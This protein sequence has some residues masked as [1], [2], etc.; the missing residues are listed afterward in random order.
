MSL[1]QM[2]LEKLKTVKCLEG[3]QKLRNQ[4]GAVFALTALLLPVLFGFMGLGYDVGNLY[5]HKARLQDTADATA[6]A[7]ARGYVNEL[8]KGSSTGVISLASSDTQTK[9]DT[10]IAALKTNAD[11]YIAKNNPVFQDKLRDD[12]RTEKFYSIGKEVTSSDRN[13]STEYFRVVLSEPVQLNFLPVIG[14]KSSADVSVYATTKLSDNEIVKVAGGESNSNENLYKPV[15]IAG[16]FF[17]DEQNLSVPSLNDDP[18]NTHDAERDYYN[19]SEVYVKKGGT[20]KTFTDSEGNPIVYGNEGGLATPKIVETDY[21][22]NEF[23]IKMR[24]EFIKKWIETLPTN[25]QSAKRAKLNEFITD[26]R[27]WQLLKDAWDVHYKEGK[28][29]FMVDSGIEKALAIFTQLEHYRSIFLT[30]LQ[31]SNYINDLAYNTTLSEWNNE[32]N[33]ELTDEL[34]KKLLDEKRWNAYNPWL[35]EPTVENWRYNWGGGTWQDYSNYGVTSNTTL[36]LQ[37]YMDN[38]MSSYQLAPKP[39]ASDEKYGLEYY[40]TYRAYNDVISWYKTSEISAEVSLSGPKHSYCY[41]SHATFK[42]NPGA[43]NVKDEI[44]VEVDG[45]YVDPETANPRNITENTPFYLFIEDDVKLKNIKIEN[46]NRPLILCYMGSYEV[47]Y[48]M[49]SGDSATDRNTIR[50]IYYNPN[51]A[52]DTHQN[53]NHIDFKGSIIADKL[54][55]HGSN[56]TFKYDVA[57]VNKWNLPFTQNIGFDTDNSGAGGDNTEV[58]TEKITIPDHLRLVLASSIT[59]D[60]HYNQA[61]VSWQLIE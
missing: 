42:P 34:F 52:G 32:E 33:K 61:R 9:K 56:D 45:F 19:A 18:S 27:N 41:L 10:A 23:G 49:K 7:G 37:Q 53:G 47:H 4:H 14:I 6:L 35:N 25:Q 5:L 11:N 12:N 38:Y 57:E 48:E 28:Q 2:V 43:T 50:G 26:L 21:D 31:S 16:S 1:Y 54:T 8:K 30:A 3:L 20:Y 36:T 15:V 60:S 39:L 59:D 13:N 24:E 51:A 40:M 22:M 29:Q 46:T 44:N 17:H 55:I 58:E